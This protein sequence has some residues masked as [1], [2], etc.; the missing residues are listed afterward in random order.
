MPDCVVLTGE[1]KEH[2]VGLLLVLVARRIVR[3]D[4]VQVEVARRN[5]RRPL[6]GRPEE[7]VAAPGRVTFAPLQLVLPDAVVIDV[8]RVRALQDALERLVVVAVELGVVERLGAFLNQGVVVV[9]LLEVEVVLAVVGVGGDELPAHRPA[10]LAQHGFDL[11]E[12]V[13][14]RLA[15]EVLDSRLVQAQTVPQFIRRGAERGVNV[16]VGQAMDRQSVDDPQR[17]RP[18]GGRVNA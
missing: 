4:E 9:G 10:D 16:L 18:V 8:R 2:L 14:R 7:Q 11:R 3:L 17:H 15:A 6:V 5:G 1:A 13:V 12:Q